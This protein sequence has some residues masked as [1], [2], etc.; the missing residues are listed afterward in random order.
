MMIRN[1]DETKR[2]NDATLS[3]L[4]DSGAKTLRLYLRQ[5]QYTTFLCVQMLRDA[6]RIEAVIPEGGEDTVAVRGGVEELYQVKTRAESVGMWTLRE[7][8]A[9]ICR[10]YSLRRSFG[11][12]CTFHFVSDQGAD[13]KEKP[14]GLPGALFRLKDVLRRLGKLSDAQADLLAQFETALCPLIVE[15]LAEH[16]NDTL[17]VAEALDLLHRTRIQTGETRLNEYNWPGDLQSA[18]RERLPGHTFDYDDLLRNQSRV[19]ALVIDR[20]ANELTIEE[21]TIRRTDVMECCQPSGS[22]ALPGSDWDAFPGKNRLEQKCH[23]GGF[24]TERILNFTRRKLLTRVTLRELD[25]VGRSSDVDQ[26]ATYLSEKQRE[27]LEDAI[28]RG[29]TA[30]PGPAALRLLKGELAQA[31]RRYFPA[32]VPEGH[33]DDFAEGLLWRE[34]E[35]CYLNWGVSDAAKAA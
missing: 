16:H 12:T 1:Q 5:V 22:S 19:Q 32:G 25:I 13:P 34:T 24:E 28:A 9:V 10:Q 2:L 29:H 17:S 26:L 3:L 8:L 21:R 20:T 27:S 14:R 35:R 7:A 6:T 30:S 4:D 31:V 33:D 15:M 11:P 23:A 18:L